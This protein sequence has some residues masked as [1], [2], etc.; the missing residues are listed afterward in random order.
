MIDFAFS[1]V[2]NILF[3]LYILFIVK[4]EYKLIYMLL[5]LV[6]ASPGFFINDILINL[7][8]ILIPIMYLFTK[9][10]RLHKNEFTKPLL[11]FIACAIISH[12]TCFVSGYYSLTM[13]FRLI[14]L[15]ELPLAITIFYHE[16]TKPNINREKIINHTS[17]MCLLLTVICITLFF[18]QDSQFASIQFM[19]IG[20]I[21][22]HRAGGIYRESSNLGS[23]MVM[24]SIFS[25]YCI[26]NNKK[27]RLN[28]LTL[29]LSILANFLS[30][31][32]ITILALIVVLLIIFARS[33]IRF[34]PAYFI[35]FIS[36]FIVLYTNSD[37]VQSFI[38]NRLLRLFKDDFLTSSNGRFTIW[39]DIFNQYLSSHRYFFGIGYKLDKVFGDNMYLFALTNTGI[40]GLTALLFLI[41][42]LFAFSNRFS[43]NDKLI[44][45][46]FTVSF[47]IVGLTC[48]IVTYSRALFILFSTF[49]ILK[50][51]KLK[52]S[53]ESLKQ[54]PAFIRQLLIEYNI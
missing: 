1:L 43:G 24:I 31:T 21:P 34:K 16:Y 23:N 50:E 9:K 5:F 51:N 22:L 53:A 7:G 52:Y 19:W 12:I 35:F 32:R 13:F 47:V 39:A 44:L 48:D 15:I 36:I 3:F 17:F 33:K 41:Y 45:M 2:V 37:I 42:R 38:S 20:K 26:L 28:I 6:I 27:K 49:V 29:F 11:F 54:N 18:I 25:I 46:M 10:K 14:R 8:D 4:R 30:Y 40:L